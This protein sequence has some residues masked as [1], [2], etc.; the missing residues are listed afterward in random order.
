MKQYFLIL[1]VITPLHAGRLSASMRLQDAIKSPPSSAKKKS[2]RPPTPFPHYARC[3][4]FFEN[5]QERAEE[6]IFLTPA[7]GATIALRR[8][9]QN[10]FNPDQ[11]KQLPPVER[12][13]TRKHKK[14]KDC[15]QCTASYCKGQGWCTEHK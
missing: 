14:R 13:I 4:S 9:A 2:I 10:P 11:K 3:N 12:P 1:L 15:A 8:K 6:L 7:E 5:P